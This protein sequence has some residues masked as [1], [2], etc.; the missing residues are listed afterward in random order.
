M[1]FNELVKK[2]STMPLFGV[3]FLSAGENPSQLR[4]QLNRWARDGKVIRIHK[5]LYTLAEPYR[6]VSSHP[7]CVANRLQEI[8][9]V[10]RHSALAWYGMIPEFVP[11]VTS[12]TLGRPR[13]LETPL[14]RFEFRHIDKKY[15]W[16]YRQI[17]VQSRQAAF[18]ARPEKA[19]LDLIYLTPGGDDAE[20]LEELRLQNFEQISRDVL[21]DFVKRFQS[22][23]LR[24]AQQAIERILAEGEGI[25]L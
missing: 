13:T 25:Q 6:K 19:L 18:V 4:L 14:G 3:S 21:D 10:S 22:P 1:K 16:G 15:F 23:K 2:V 11:V 9:Y 8:S 20:F 5:G 17:E 12:V 24:R 7:F